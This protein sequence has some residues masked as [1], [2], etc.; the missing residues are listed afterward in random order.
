MSNNK[1]NIS[2][3]LVGW[4]SVVLRLHSPFCVTKL[5]R[6][7]IRIRCTKRSSGCWPLT[8]HRLRRRLFWKRVAG[9]NETESVPQSPLESIDFHFE[10]KDRRSGTHRSLFIWLQSSVTMWWCSDSNGT[11]FNSRC[12][13]RPPHNWNSPTFEKYQ[14][15][16]IIFKKIRCF[17]LAVAQNNVFSRDEGYSN[18]FC[19]LEGEILFSEHHKELKSF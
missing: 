11:S 8:S 9:E 12:H 14:H 7:I 13:F 2:S 18:Q 15:L 1:R 10:N 19:A 17:S 4:R 6:S 3:A 16:R 5:I